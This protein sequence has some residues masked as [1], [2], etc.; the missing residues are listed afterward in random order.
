MVFFLYRSKLPSKSPA[1]YRDWKS[2]NYGR[3]TR[4]IPWHGNDLKR[5]IWWLLKVL[6]RSITYSRLFPI[7]IGRFLS[8]IFTQCMIIEASQ[9]SA[10]EQVDEL[11]MGYSFRVLSVLEC[12]PH[13]WAIASLNGSTEGGISA[14][15]W[16]AR[17]KSLLLSLSMPDQ[18]TR[19]S[20]ARARGG[21]SQLVHAGVP[22]K[23]TWL[24]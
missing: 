9:A 13:T 6:L 1:I 10:L 20:G 4:F 8:L 24:K 15:L 12:K 5:R 11:L 2:Y 7:K 3:L 18:I 21:Q 23:I 17:T 16:E 14:R 19:P 22:H